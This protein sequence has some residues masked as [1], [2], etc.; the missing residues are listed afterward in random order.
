M[1]FSYLRHEQKIHEKFF[2]KLN[3]RYAHQTPAKYINKQKNQ[4]GIDP[5]KDVGCPLT[6]HGGI[7]KIYRRFS[8]KPVFY[9]ELN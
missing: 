5:L 8:V 6:F 4:R 7:F 2:L 9:V 1:I 3:F